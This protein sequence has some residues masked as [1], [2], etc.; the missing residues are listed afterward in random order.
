VYNAAALS[1]LGAES[2]SGD[3]SMNRIALRLSVAA[4]TLILGLTTFF[5]VNRL[6]QRTRSDRAKAE[7]VRLTNQFHEAVFAGDTN[8]LNNILAD[9]FKGIGHTNMGIFTVSKAEQLA[10]SKAGKEAQEDAAESIPSM[11]LSNLNVHEE[12]ETIVVEADAMAL[13]GKERF[14]RHLIYTFAARQGHLQLISSKFK[15]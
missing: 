11:T 12:G 6:R 10:A 4:L 13:M 7:A 5:A 15:Q 8:A 1:N 14:S 3:R 9:D 2:W